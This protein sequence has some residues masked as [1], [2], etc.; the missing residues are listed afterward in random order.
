MCETYC[1]VFLRSLV[2]GGKIYIHPRRHEST[3]PVDTYFRQPCTEDIPADL[4]A[5]IPDTGITRDDLRQQAK[6]LHLFSRSEPDLGIDKLCVGG[7]IEERGG[8]KGTPKA[9]F[10]SKMPNRSGARPYIVNVPV[11]FGIKKL[12][13]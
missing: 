10:G 4:F 11:R 2:R 1:K 3:R 6:V 8:V 13:R 7:K 9:F 12:N 5:L